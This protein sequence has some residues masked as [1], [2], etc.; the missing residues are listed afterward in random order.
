MCCVV[1]REGG[2]FLGCWWV[3]HVDGVALLDREG[4]AEVELA[5]GLVA[6]ADRV[7]FEVEQLPVRHQDHEP[8]PMIGPGSREAGKAQGGR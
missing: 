4:R 1:G 2:K 7:R 8:A 3:P 5:E 6:P